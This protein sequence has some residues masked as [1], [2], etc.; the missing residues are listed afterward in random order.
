MTLTNPSR[1]PEPPSDL[2][3][4]GSEVWND[5]LA[6]RKVGA[7]HL[8]VI[9]NCCRIVDR[10][11]DLSSEVGGELTVINDKGDEVANPLLTEHRQQFLALRAI[12]KDLGIDRLPAVEKTEENS[13]ELFLQKRRKEREKGT[14]G[15]GD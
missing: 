11:D 6:N 3:F 5:L 10:L 2:G 12:L 14:V 9:H 1:I 15:N 4:S 7:T 8:S 13:L